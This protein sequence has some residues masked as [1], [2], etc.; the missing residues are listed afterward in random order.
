MNSMTKKDKIE[1]PV[2]VDIST[3]ELV[4]N[5][6]RLLR[7]AFGSSFGSI[8]NQVSEIDK[9]RRSLAVRGE[10]NREGDIYYAEILVCMP[11]FANKALCKILRKEPRA[12]VNLEAAPKEALSHEKEVEYTAIW[13]AKSVEPAIQYE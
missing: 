4:F 6:P 10:L 11:N 1:C 3:A 5:D 12:V 7:D 9:T 2:Y 13:R 8:E